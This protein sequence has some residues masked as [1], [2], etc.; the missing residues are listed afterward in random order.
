MQNKTKNR[1]FL[2]IFDLFSISGKLS[3]SIM[4]IILTI[5]CVT[6]SSLESSEQKKETGR[7]GEKKI[8]QGTPKTHFTP[9]EMQL[10]FNS[11]MRQQIR[12]GNK[13]F[14]PVIDNRRPVFVARD[15]N[16]NGHTEFFA[17]FAESILENETSG[18]LRSVVSDLRNIY[19]SDIYQRQFILAVF[20]YHETNN[21]KKFI[22]E[23]NIILEGT[24]A[25]SSLKELKIDRNNKIYGISATFV[26]SAGTHEDIVIKGRQAYS[27][28]SIRNT[29]SDSTR[30]E[31]INNTGVI[32]L[33]RHN[34]VFVDGLG[35]ETFITWYIFDGER[36]RSVKTVNTVK[37]LRVFL[38]ESQMHLEARRTDRFIRRAVAPPVLEKLNA[39]R[40]GQERIMQRIFYPVK[41]EYSFLIDIN[42]MLAAG[43]EI[44]FIFPEIYESPF[45]R[46]R[47]GLYSFTTYVRVLLRNGG[48]A[49]SSEN[50]DT[51][52]IIN[53]EIYLV[54]IY[55]A[56]NPFEDNRFFF[57]VH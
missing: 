37:D 30:K 6:G 5:S 29:L 4:L 44:S 17:L 57:F 42:R 49:I 53:E 21:E 54:R 33:L 52:I 3:I 38:R 12:I 41:W 19:R 1:R 24:G 28:T 31:D 36:F 35:V 51:D 27:I 50:M 7:E 11:V 23:Q 9:Q 2:S 32:D 22:H 20:R 18:I 47:D 43:N 55:M 56:E 25:F 48:V 46:D 34:K 10:F 45:R 16:N 26:T 40:I 8:L 15:I 14:L 13:R 39:A